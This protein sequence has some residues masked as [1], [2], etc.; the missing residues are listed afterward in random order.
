MNRYELVR[1]VLG[2]AGVALVGTGLWLVH[3][4]AA[5]VVAGMLLVGV[6]VFIMRRS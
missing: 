4:S 2:L 3:P 6:S 5:M 1:D